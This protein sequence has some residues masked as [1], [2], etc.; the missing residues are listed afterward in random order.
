ML[1]PRRKEARVKNDGRLRV[2]GIQYLGVPGMLDL[3]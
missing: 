2:C 1:S 3:G